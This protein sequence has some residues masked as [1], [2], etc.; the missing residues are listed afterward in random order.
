[1]LGEMF[2]VDNQLGGVGI[3]TGAKG[4]AVSQFRED[5]SYNTA[6]AILDAASRLSFGDIMLLE[7][8]E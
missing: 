7:A 6:E 2:M 4:F 8:Q 3:I 1:V 5:Y